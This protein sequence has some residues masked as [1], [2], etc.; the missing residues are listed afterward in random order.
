MMSP[1]LTPAL[2]AGEPDSTEDTQT[3][4]I[5]PSSDCTTTPF[6]PM[7]VTSFPERRS[8]KTRS[9]SSRPMAKYWAVA[10]MPA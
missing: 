7:E 3:P 10:S 2:S 1:P 8:S 5:E 6:T 4:E 9:N